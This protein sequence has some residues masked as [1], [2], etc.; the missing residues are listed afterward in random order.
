MP[1]AGSIKEICEPAIS[2][3]PSFNIT[4]IS[5]IRNDSTAVMDVNEVTF[6]VSITVDCLLSRLGYDKLT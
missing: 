3:L 2:S 6:Y 4:N 1:L 5:V